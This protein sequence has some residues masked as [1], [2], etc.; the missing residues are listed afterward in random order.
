MKLRLLL[1]SIF[2]LTII[3]SAS[4]QVVD[5]GSHYIGGSLYYNYDGGPGT[6]TTYNFANGT[7]QYTISNLT[8]FQINPEFGYFLSKNWT[9]GIQPNYSHSSGT[10]TSVFT[11]NTDAASNFTSSDNYHIDV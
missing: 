10:E 4:A 9:I 2:I 5:K 3:G 8:T 6:T 7:T 1:L 11:S